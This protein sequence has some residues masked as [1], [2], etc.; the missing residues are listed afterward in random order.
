[1]FLRILVVKGTPLGGSEFKPPAEETI[2]HAAFIWIKR[3]KHCYHVTLLHE[4]KYVKWEGRL[5]RMV[6]LHLG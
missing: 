6:H 3:W 1:M 2:F 5:L 4:L